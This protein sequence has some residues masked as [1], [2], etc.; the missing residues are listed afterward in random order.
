MDTLTAMVGLGLSALVVA[1]LVY[2]WVVRVQLQRLHDQ[3]AE[4]TGWISSLDDKKLGLDEPSNRPPRIKRPKKVDP[5]GLMLVDSHHG[6]YSVS[7]QDVLDDLESRFVK[8]DIVLKRVRNLKHLEGDSQDELHLLTTLW[9]FAVP[10]KRLVE[11]LTDDVKHG[12]RIIWH[13]ADFGSDDISVEELLENTPIPYCLYVH[14]AP[15]SKPKGMQTLVDSPWIPD[16]ATIVGVDADM[17]FSPEIYGRIRAEV[18]PTRQFY[19]PACGYLNQAGA[20]Y[21]VEDDNWGHGFIGVAKNDAIAV[22]GYAAGIYRYKNTWGGEETDFAERIR[23]AGLR[24]V[25]DIDPRI[26]AGHHER[27]ETNLWY[28]TC[29]TTDFHDENKVDAAEQPISSDPA[30]D[31]L[32][33]PILTHGLGN[34]LFQIAAALGLAADNGG[35][36]R[37][38]V[39][40]VTPERYEKNKSAITVDWQ[41]FDGFGGHSIAEIDGLPRSLEELFPRLGFE[42]ETIEPRVLRKKASTYVM[43]PYNLGKDGYYYET[44]DFGPLSGNVTLEG[45]F[46]SHKHY[47]SR[48]PEIRDKLQPAEAVIRHIDE[49]FGALLSRKPVAVHFR[50]GLDRD[51]YSPLVPSAEWYQKALDTIP[52]AGPLL[53]CS[54][55]IEAA[56]RFLGKLKTEREVVFVK[57]Q[58]HYVDMFVMSH[59]SH[60]VFS[61][62]TLAA[63]AAIL[64]PNEDKVVVCHPHYRVKYGRASALPNWV[65]LADDNEAHQREVWLGEKA[66]ELPSS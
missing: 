64:N 31:T 29:A 42:T 43:E 37:F 8:R 65:V 34:K 9:N 50:F 21:G 49:N 25:R 30:Q 15:F 16:D 6:F 1:L 24:K 55:D 57:G 3:I 22:G 60:I 14:E 33:T 40:S 35:R 44:Q 45:Y 23:R 12:Q 10:F 19:A 63:W 32:L 56:R 20:V 41:D 46:F 7:L 62:S 4:M 39:S 36:T 48:L 53:V 5:Q 28:E 58:P 26:T 59:C 11:Q 27:P 47:S 18:V 13:V 51:H 52:G 2:A 38:V 66:W 17:A 61:I 54:D